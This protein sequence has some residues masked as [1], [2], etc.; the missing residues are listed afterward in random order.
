MDR[1]LVDYKRKLIRR[2]KMIE[3][4]WVCKE[5][6]EKC[7]AVEVT[8]DYA[9]THCTHG[10]RGT[11]H[12]GTYVSDCCGTDFAEYDPEEADAELS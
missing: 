5:C 10:Q 2:E 11:H 8:F 3:P 1:F 6:G 4:T 9:G 12:T 7:R